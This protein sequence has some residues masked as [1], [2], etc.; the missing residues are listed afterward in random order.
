MFG[1]GFDLAILS[2]PLAFYAIAA[3][4]GLKV[5]LFTA[6]RRFCPIATITSWVS[7]FGQLKLSGGASSWH[8]HCSTP[9]A[10]FA[11]PP[12]PA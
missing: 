5:I 9:Q 10:A 3:V 7:C 8:R 6:P 1:G 2:G 4:C 12:A 11:D